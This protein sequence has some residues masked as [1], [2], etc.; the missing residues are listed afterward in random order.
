MKSKFETFTKFKMWKAKG[1]NQN[2]R[3][4]KCL[5]TDNCTEYKDG[6]FLKFCK[7]HGIKRHFTILE[8]T[9]TKWGGYVTKPL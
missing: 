5:S 1:E 3:K 9:S 7:E 2:G 6:N 8:N 4:I